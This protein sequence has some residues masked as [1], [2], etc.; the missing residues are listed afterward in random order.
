MILLQGN[1]NVN[2]TIE[3]MATAT[4]TDIISGME[5]ESLLTISSYN[6]FVYFWI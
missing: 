6:R 3:K 5:C 1:R 4:A 2:E